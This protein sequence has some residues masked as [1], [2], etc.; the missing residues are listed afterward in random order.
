MQLPSAG[1][2]LFHMKVC[3]FFAHL[4]SG[5]INIPPIICEK[6]NFVKVIQTYLLINYN[7]DMLS[8]YHEKTLTLGFSP[9]SKLKICQ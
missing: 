5:R 9:N 6:D 2:I 8:K 1:A 4:G 3:L 7:N